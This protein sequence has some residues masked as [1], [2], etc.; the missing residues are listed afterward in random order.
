LVYWSIGLLV[1]WSIGLLV[2]ISEM[3]ERLPLRRLF[4][5]LAFIQFQQQTPYT[6]LNCVCGEPDGTPC[7]L[8]TMLVHVPMG[9][10][11]AKGALVIPAFVA[12]I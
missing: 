2:K 6:S 12:G 4:F 5:A 9:L 8:V 3:Q 7:L 11:A 10:F 1:Y